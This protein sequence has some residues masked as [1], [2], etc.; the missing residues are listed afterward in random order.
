MAPVWSLVVSDQKNSVVSKRKSVNRTEDNKTIVPNEMASSA[1]ANEG[2]IAETTRVARAGSVA[3]A[4]LNAGLTSSLT[5]AAQQSVFP[6]SHRSDESG[7][8]AEDCPT[9]QSGPQRTQSAN[10]IAP[11]RAEW[12][13]G[14]S[15]L[16]N[17]VAFKK[18]AK[19]KMNSCQDDS[20]WPRHSMV[21]VGLFERVEDAAMFDDPAATGFGRR[22]VNSILRR[23]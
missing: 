13:W 10:S 9:A 23:R 3:W 21:P 1:K 16:G 14:Q 12:W 7:T 19:L 17:M 6:L 5:T 8:A 22:S 15:H 4:Q 11:A 20:G 2:Q 18:N